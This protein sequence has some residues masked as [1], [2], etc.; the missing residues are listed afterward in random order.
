M[1]IIKNYPFKLK[2]AFSVDIVRHGP[3]NYN[4][5]LV[6]EEEGADPNRYVD[7]T[8]QVA[9]LTQ[10]GVELASAKAS[11]YV[12]K[13][14]PKTEIVVIIS[15]GEM[16][17]YQTAA[18]YFQ[19]LQKKGVEV[20]EGI[21]SQAT[22]YPVGINAER[23]PEFEGEYNRV[24]LHRNIVV[25]PIPSLRYPA[26]WIQDMLEPPIGSPTTTFRGLNEDLL[27][28]EDR[29]RFRIARAVIE[30]L[31]PDEAR[32]WG[33][34]YKKFEGGPYPFDIIPSANENHA[35]MLFGLKIL[36]R[37]QRDRRTQEFE[38]MKGKR[39]RYLILTHEENILRLARSYFDVAKVKN[40]D[41]IHLEIPLSGTSQFRAEFNGQIRMVADLHISEVAQR[42]NRP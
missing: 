3:S 9:D 37:I 39:I 8:S 40:C 42:R 12:E 28:E 34:N 6:L 18:I 7:H 14:D 26:I 15:S 25:N 13:I 32:T 5:Y 16:R 10:E 11:E 35:R 23:N 38:R 31:G 30:N 33:E 36:R 24:S 41:L 2:P 21:P 19:A 4:N 1:Y 29:E 17:A 20:F 27:S 22:G